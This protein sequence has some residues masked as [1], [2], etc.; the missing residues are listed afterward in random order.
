[1]EMVASWQ[2]FCNN[3]ALADDRND[4]IEFSFGTEISG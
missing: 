3:A 1:M 4:R 2:R